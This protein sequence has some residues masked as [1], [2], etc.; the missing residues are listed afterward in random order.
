MIKN[1]KEIAKD[2][3]IYGSTS[4]LS[5]IVGVFLVPFY[6]RELSP[7]AY[8]IIAITSLFAAFLNPIASLG[9][10]SALFRYFAITNSQLEKKQYFTSAI[11]VKTGFVIIAV[12]VLL[13]LYGVANSLLFN[14]Q[15]IFIQYLILLGT[16]L[17]FNVASLGFVILRVQR[18]AKKVASI[19]MVVMLVSLAVSI[20]LVI[21]LK[22]GVTGAL[23][24]TLIASILRATLL[25][26]VVKTHIHVTLYNAKTVRTLLAYGLPQVPHKIN[27]TIIGL[28][29]LFII[30]QK[31]G[32]VV[33]G[34]YL[35]ARKFAKPLSLIVSVVQQ[36]WS[37]YKFQIH[38]EE[39]AP[40]RVFSQI[41]SFYWIVLVFG[42]SILSIVA[43]PLYSI[44]ID[45]R[46]WSGI[47]YVPFL[48]FMGVLEAM[49]FTVSTGFELS[50]RQK[51]SPVASFIA[52]IVLVTI[53]ISTL[54]FY[55]PY[56]FFIAQ[57]LAYATMGGILLMEARR[58]MIIQYPFLKILLFALIN[59]IAVYHYYNHYN[60]VVGIAVTFIA[61][62]SLAIVVIAVY[63]WDIVRIK[64]LSINN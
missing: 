14:N 64:L 15:L 46:Y 26:S 39:K 31:L 59:I 16:F 32:L 2:G 33:S 40:E 50:E 35:V 23:L 42:W 4:V 21:I 37:P 8:G 34:L 1:L 43:I 45:S 51:M 20:Y 63:S 52:L 30:N 9:M 55:P 47:P 54:D 12:C 56:G 3:I 28:F 29:T 10:D 49:R 57:G 48:M 17:S 5:Q 38:R 22:L 44:L 6:T 24:A 41:I 18:R 11:V 7:E 25:L 53:S 13:P 36:A 62:I 27:A 61:L 19:N 58:I 60:L